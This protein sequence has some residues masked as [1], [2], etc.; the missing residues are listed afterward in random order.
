M[1]NE[2]LKSLFKI[3]EFVKDA[4]DDLIVA[5]ED[6]HFFRIQ[7]KGSEQK[8]RGLKWNGKRPDLIVCHEK[9]TEIY[10]PET[11]WI[12]NQDY[13][14]SSLIHVHEAYEIEFEDGSKEIISGDHR[15]FIE[16]QGWKFPWMLQK[17]ENVLENTTDDIMNAILN[18]EKNHFKNITINQKLKNVW[19]N[20]MQI[21]LIMSLHLEQNTTQKI[22][23][24]LARKLKNLLVPILLGKQCTVQ[25]DV[26]AS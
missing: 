4:E 24:L 20:G 9:D 2:Q 8:V 11:G 23:K 18:G 7:A 25:K 5:T 22:K 3:K 26:L 19:R 6:G 13:P 17:N 21:I 16:G 15:Y 14:D 1:G 10:T 12:K